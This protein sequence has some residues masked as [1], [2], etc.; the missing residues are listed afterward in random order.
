V[1]APDPDLEA[2]YSQLQTLVVRRA[3]ALNEQD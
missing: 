1:A 3:E 2:A